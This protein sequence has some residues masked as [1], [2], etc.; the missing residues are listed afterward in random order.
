LFRKD[1]MENGDLAGDDRPSTCHVI[2]HLHG[3]ITL[4]ITPPQLPDIFFP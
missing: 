2:E 4:A 1:F 3:L